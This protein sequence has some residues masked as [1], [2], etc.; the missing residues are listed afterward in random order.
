MI[1]DLAGF[2]FLPPMLAL[3]GA[4]T[5]SGCYRDDPPRSSTA[6]ISTNSRNEATQQPEDLLS[7]AEKESSKQSASNKSTPNIIPTRSGTVQWENNPRS[8]QLS[9]KLAGDDIPSNA[10]CQVIAESLGQ[11]LTGSAGITGGSTPLGPIRVNQTL[12]A[13]LLPGTYKILIVC[14]SDSA[15]WNGESSVKLRAN[16]PIEADIRMFVID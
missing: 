8:A 12:E 2:K 6:T 14:S 16:N 10:T 15:A 5:L 13:E 7:S 1:S 9:V 11:V 4:V 3:A